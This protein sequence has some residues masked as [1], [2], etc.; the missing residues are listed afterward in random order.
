MALS[1][2][3]QAGVAGL[4]LC[5]AAAPGFGAG[6]SAK[7]Q[8]RKDSTDK[9]DTHHLRQ[10]REFVVDRSA[11]FIRA[12]TNKPIPGEFTVAKTAPTVKLQILSHLEPEF[13]TGADQYMA[14]WAT[15]APVGRGDDN[16]F[17]LAASDH[18]AKGCDIN[19]YE[20][21]PKDDVVE[22]ILDVDELLGWTDDMYTDGKIHGH[23]GVGPDGNLWGATHYGVE[24]ND[25]WYDK[26]YRGSWLFSYNTRTGEAKNWG[27]PL[28]GNCLPCFAVDGKRGIFFGTGYKFTALCWDCNAR[29]VRFAG[30]PPNGWIWWDRAMLCDEATGKFWGMEGSREPYCMMSFEP[31]RN[32]FERFEQLPVPENPIQKKQAKLRG[33]TSRPAQDGWYYWAT[34]NGAFFRFKPEGEKGPEIDP[35]GVTWETGV[36]VKQIGIGPRG[37]YLY[38]W[39]GS[40]LVQF[41]V[42]TRRK[43]ALWFPKDYYAAKY[44]YNFGPV[45]GLEVSVDGS[46][47]VIAFNGTFGH[48]VFGHPS[49]CVVEIPRSERRL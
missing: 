16:R 23:M 11:E 28:L 45:Y 9:A 32:R 10:K 40:A 33:C 3:R 46:F 21:R 47:V 39:G 41:D 4:I 14:C 15:W 19:L 6:L 7:E 22:R 37:R 8:Q 12:P 48:G 43:K 2:A 25:Q 29:T 1:R 26:G 42:E 27:V 30:Y 24:P 5:L 38:Y 31:A 18:L 20:Y 13:F 34:W 17:Y 44:G 36:D 49:V 35:L